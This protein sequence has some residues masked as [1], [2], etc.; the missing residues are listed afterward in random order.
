[1]KKVVLLLLSVFI[2]TLSSCGTKD[3]NGDTGNSGD[4]GNTGNTSGDTGD[5][6]DTGNSGN[7]GDSG[8]SGNSGDSGNSG[9]SGDSGN[10]G[11]TGN[12]G[13]SCPCGTDDEDDDKD[14]ISN[15]VEGCEDLDG[16]GLPNCLDIDSDGDGLA[17][18]AE[19]PEQPCRDT[20][21]DGIPDF[22]DKDSDND[23]LTDKEEKEKGTDPYNKDTDGDGSDDLAEIVYG[24]DPLDDSSKI[25]AGLFYVVL[26]YQAQWTVSRIWEFDTDISKIDVAFLIDLSGSMDQEQANLRAKI[27]D[28][29][30]AKV[31][32]LNDGTLNAAYALVHFMDFEKDMSKVY[33]V[34]QFVTT[35]E[36]AIKTALD[37]TPGTAGGTECHWLVLYAATTEDDIVG[38]CSTSEIMGTKT[39]CNIPKPD[40]SG[41]EG[42]RGGLC[43]RDKAM[44]ILI[45]ITD[46]DFTD[47]KMPPVNELASTLAQKSLV[48]QNAKFIGIDSSSTSGSTA[49]KNKYESISQLTGTLD[50][51]GKSFNF[52]VGTDAVAGDGK[53][54]SEKI[55][56][57]IESLT[58][59]VQMDVWVAGDSDE[60]CNDKSAAEFIIGGIPIKADPPEGAGID[61]ANMKFTDVNPGTVVTFDVQFQNTFCPNYTDNPLLFKAQ[62]MVL[63]EGAYLSKKEVNVIVPKSDSK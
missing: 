24:S 44:P 61:T 22:L 12:T 46:E 14:G 49:I 9:N 26:P 41:K 30:I 3:E 36:D 51:N 31:K 18:S 32:T 57:A 4:T 28:D 17:D 47:N 20:D 48:E 10:T 16:D 43:F 63:G 33:F 6:G 13:D 54:M 40:C 35:D 21:G 23:G 59:F 45:M 2:F 34:D 37:N 19:C 56:E 60:L 50:K 42:N 62:A 27:K 25:P 5:S 39:T 15:G 29:V 1:M 8:N 55:A 58:A 53:P 11:D 38:P 52:S 7:S